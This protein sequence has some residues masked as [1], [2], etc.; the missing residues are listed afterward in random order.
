MR[1]RL[2]ALVRVLPFLAVL[3]LAGAI[4]GPP[5]ATRAE[6]S[7]QSGTLAIAYLHTERL[8]GGEVWVASATGA[9]RRTV[10]TFGKGV[11]AFDV[12][13]ST[14]A[15]VSDPT[16]NPELVILDL[17]SG[18]EK[19]LSGDR[20]SDTFVAEDGSVL[21]ATRAG[22]GP[23][24]A[25]TTIGRVDAATGA[26]TDIAV[27]EEPGA[28]ILWHDPAANEFML[29]PRGCDPGLWAL[30]MHDAKSGAVKSTVEV[31][32]C[33][34]ASVAPNGKQALITEGCGLLD[35][36]AFKVYD[37][38]AGSQREVRLT[39]TNLSGHALV[40]A[41][42]GSRAAFGTAAESMNS[43]AYQG[44]PSGQAKS[45]GIWLLD[46]A[47]LAQKKLWQDEGLES[48]AIDWSPDGSRLLVASVEA[49]GRCR[50]FTIVVETGEAVPVDGIN[51]C[52]TN[53]TM[54]GFATLP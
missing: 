6:P 36:P 28:E 20:V 39:G 44:D 8:D 31:R 15:L 23:G 9:N 7:G 1:S 29:T 34:S 13:G 47:T 50:Y 52:G 38:Q 53:G 27:L 43:P 37:L 46:A 22:C 5:A 32:G 42:D 33:G 54:V 35:A 40:Y 10:T 48:W 18:A 3:A 24:T 30:R 2:F 41:P 21:F 51:G 26:R 4:A 12:R 25:K 11:R 16:P 49:Q 19:R 14:L 17:A 45:G